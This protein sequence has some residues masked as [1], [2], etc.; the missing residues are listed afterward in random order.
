MQTTLIGGTLDFA[1]NNCDENSSSFCVTTKTVAAYARSDTLQKQSRSHLRFRHVPIHLGI[2]TASKAGSCT[3]KS[4]QAAL[5]SC[6]TGVSQ[7]IFNFHKLYSKTLTRIVIEAKSLIGS[8][9]L[10]IT[11]SITHFEITGFT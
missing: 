5:T 2:V 7:P 6:G 1:T 4:K 9:S 8:Y 3:R 10:A 11:D